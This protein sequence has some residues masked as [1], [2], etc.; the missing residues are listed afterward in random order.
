MKTSPSL[1]AKL[2]HKLNSKPTMTPSAAFLSS[3]VTFPGAGSG[4]KA[5]GNLWIVDDIAS[6]GFA[7]RSGSFWMIWKLLQESSLVPYL[8]KCSFA[9]FSLQS[10]P[11]PPFPV[12]SPPYI[13]TSPDPLWVLALVNTRPH[14]QS[15]LHALYC[16]SCCLWVLHTQMISS[17]FLFLNPFPLTCLH[18]S[19][20]NDTNH[21]NW[22]E[23]WVPL[24]LS[25]C[26]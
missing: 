25:K 10:I 18:P 4:S 20:Q 23:T 16:W 14:A 24:P 15:S 2:W 8:W 19:W 7:V 13:N 21:F 22:R 12:T 6:P 9:F 17:V 3:F 5:Q 26:L 1:S 11:S